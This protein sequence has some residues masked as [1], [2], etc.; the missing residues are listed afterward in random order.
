MSFTIV[1]G[2]DD[3]ELE[4]AVRRGVADG[5]ARLLRVPEHPDSVQAML[6]SDAGTERGSLTPPVRASAGSDENA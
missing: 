6:P 4:E 5:L 3:L 1:T 2:R